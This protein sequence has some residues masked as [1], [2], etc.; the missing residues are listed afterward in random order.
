MCFT[1]KI[2]SG[3]LLLN[4][5][6]FTVSCS[7]G[8]VQTGS[9]VTSFSG[10]GSVTVLSPTSLKI[11]WSKN[12][13]VKEYM[14]FQNSNTAPLGKTALDYFVVENLDPNTTYSFKVIGDTS[15]TL[16]GSDKEIKVTTWSRFLGITSATAKTLTSIEISWDYSYT[17]QKYLVYYRKDAAP[18]ATSTNNWAT[19]SAETSLNKI[20]INGLENSSKYYFVVHAVYRDTEKEIANKVLSLTTKTSFAAPTYS[21]SSVSIGSVPTVAIDPTEDATHGENF[22]KT[23]VL[24]NGVPVSDPLVGKG[25]IIVSANANLPLGKVENISLKI[26][27]ADGNKT[28]SMTIEGLVTYIKGMPTN[29]ETPS[30]LNLSLGSS[31]MG[32]VLARGDFNCD[33]QDDLAVGLPSISVASVG[34]NS[35]DAGAVVVYYT[36]QD[37]NDPTKL[38]LNT[39]GTPSLNPSEGNPLLIT[40]DDLEEGTSLGASLA[41]GNF[42]G[43]KNGTNPCEDLLVGAP[44]DNVTQ[45]GLGGVPQPSRSGA[46]YLFFGS[47]KGLSTAGHISDIATNASTCNGSLS[48]AICGPVKLF[49][50][51]LDIPTGLTA[52]QQLVK[53]AGSGGNFDQFGQALSFIGDFNADG[54]DDIAIGAPNANFD[55][56]L[57]NISTSS[58]LVESTGAVF[59]FFGSKFGLGYEYPEAN[60]VPSPASLKTRYLKVFAPIPQTGARFGAAI[61]GGADIDGRY[62]ILSADG[63]YYGGGDMVVGSPGF[64]YE[65]YNTQNLLAQGPDY[66]VGTDRNSDSILSS[67]SGNWWDVGGVSLSA[68]TNYYGFPQSGTVGAA[69]IYFG[70]SSISAPGVAESP[71]RQDFWKCGRRKM[72]VNEHYSC[73]F[74]NANVRLLTP[75]AS[76]SATN[77]T[78]FGSA[79]AVIGNKSRFKE[80]VAPALLNANPGGVP[81]SDPNQDGYSD[82]VVSAPNA[83]V[84]TKS[85]VG[86]LQ[87]YYGNSDRYF[88]PADFYNIGSSAP[89][90]YPDTG[91]NNVSCVAFNGNADRAA[92]KPVIMS[93]LSLGA[94]A[95]IGANNAQFSVGDVTGDGVLDLA[96]GAA[97]DNVVG[98]GSGAALVYTGVA[99]GGL[100]STYK[101]IYTTSA[102]TQENLGSSVVIGNFNGDKNGSY[103]YGDLFAGA[104]FDSVNRPGGGAVYGFYTQNTSLPSTLSSHNLLITENIAS[105]TDYG[106]GETRLVG[107]IN[108]D[109]YTDAISKTTSF[110]PDGSKSVDAVVYFGSSIGLV[111]TSF[112]LSNQSQIFKLPNSGA[113]CYPN[114][115]PAQGM[116]LNQIPLPQKIAKPMNQSGMWAFMGLEAGDVNKDGFGD[117]FFLPSQAGTYSTLYFG[118]RTGLLNVVDPSW[119]P[120]AGDPQIVSQQLSAQ[121]SYQSSFFATEATNNRSPF[122]AADFNQDG[123]SDLVVGLP[124]NDSRNMNFGVIPTDA[125]TANGLGGG[126]VKGGN[127]GWNCA[128]GGST[129]ANCTNGWPIRQ[130]GTIRILYGSAAGY[131]TPQRNNG[132]GDLTRGNIYDMENSE[133][134]PIKPCESNT[135]ASPVCSAVLM[136]NPVFENIDYG[137]EK[138]G[139][140][141]GQSVAAL[142]INNDGYKDLLVSAPYYEDLSCYSDPN[143]A[144]EYGRVYVFYG[145]EFGLLAGAARIYYEPNLGLS[146]PVAFADDKA[147]KNTNGGKVRAIMPSLV[148]NGFIENQTGRRFGYSMVTAGDVNGDLYEDLIIGTPQESIGGVARAGAMYMYYG[149]LCPADNHDQIS[150]YFQQAVNLNTQKY[151]VNQAPVGVSVLLETNVVIPDASITTSCFRGAASKMK[152]LPQKFFV[153]SAVA[154]ENWGLSIYTGKPKKGD[155]NRD[156]FDDIIVGSPYFDDS[157]TSRSD[158]GQGVVFFGSEVGLYAGDFPTTSVI[159]TPTGQLRPYSIIPTQYTSGSRFFKIMNST[160]DINGDGTMDLLVPSQEYSGEGPFRGVNIGTFLIFN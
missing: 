78:G 6:L 121:T 159:A 61:A 142:D 102:G 103:P 88:N 158:I 120:A 49:E 115:N 97:G 80:N 135:N 45:V 55:G 18:D 59:I 46:A 108:N 110:Q 111:T 39:T 129:S 91:N 82:V 19:V 104:P 84:G 43:D 118:S 70:R 86:I 99:G 66:S 42:N 32:R 7:D 105:F 119:Q 69:F 53:N 116:T 72:S 137:Y 136:D 10:I 117:V 134:K 143:A 50:N 150:D 68:A 113:D 83:R 21:I 63:N 35:T 139:H 67:I 124:Q 74:D 25:Q 20:L 148:D 85:N 140:L 138:L 109:G 155:F 128:G 71:T 141:F 3:F 98:A 122:V 114:T 156:G 107:D 95:V 133:N 160:G 31:Y 151:F 34:V 40:F 94:G 60:G 154:N 81:F 24:W 100:S 76:L 48:N 41:A 89:N 149:P 62:K 58:R 47:T 17:P 4:L 77:I 147:L 96:V 112:C 145:G 79:V 9:S 125:D 153:L 75:R 1:K 126:S 93:S 44:N 13:S 123:Y 144:R 22:F 16:F 87:V 157:V 56:R 37:P 132:S 27:Y 54:Y 131:Q 14:I 52:G 8:G 30:I 51:Q 38:I 57:T 65:N 92:C 23:S 101:K 33:G 127:T 90:A 130:H 73:L 5:A 28:E 11:S 146:C 2:L 15:T 26:D 152:P 12:S 106:L 64:R 36:K 29:K